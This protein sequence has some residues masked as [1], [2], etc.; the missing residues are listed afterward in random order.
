M[1][2]AHAILG[3]IAF[4]QGEDERARARMEASLA[5]QRELGNQHGIAGILDD[6]ATVAGEQ[7]DEERQEAA[8][9]ESLALYRELG[10]KGGIALALGDLGM[11]VW[12]RGE[13][14][15]AAAFLAESLALYR[16]VGERSSVARLLGYQS[17]V[18]SFGR[19]YATAE[20]LSRDCL[21]L[22]R[23]V[24]DPWAIGRYL[25][26]LAGALFARGQAERGAT[27]LAAAAALRERLGARLPPAFQS[28]HDRMVAAMR[29]AVGE[30]GFVAAWGAGGAMPIEDALAAALSA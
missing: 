12:R 5:I 3:Q 8:L 7:G 23:E 14:D 25:P 2:T 27:L 16:E 6:L 13:V 24:G 18:A 9:A 15:R 19:E 21:T 30:E 28:A 10:H 22:Y 29:T 26:V 1:A 11:L 20:A 4:R 17:V